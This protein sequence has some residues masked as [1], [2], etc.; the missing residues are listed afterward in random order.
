MI[1]ILICFLAFLMTYS[2][3]RNFRR[4]ILRKKIVDVPNERSSH[5]KPVA[6]GGGLIIVLVCLTFYTIYGLFVSGEFSLSYLIGAGFIA[7]V[8]WIDDLKSIS[9]PARFA[10]HASAAALMIWATGAFSTI[11]LPFL[12]EIQTSYFGVLLTFLWIVWLTNAYNFM[13]GIDGIAALQA[14]IN[15]IGWFYIG[16]LY[17]MEQTSLYG[18]IIAASCFGFLPHNWQPAKIFMGDVGSAFLGFTFA[19]FPLLAVGENSPHT[20]IPDGYLPLIGIVLVWGFL[21]DTVFTLLRRIS[22]FEKIWEAHRQHI[23]QK[24]VIEGLQHSSAAIL[25]GAVAAFTAAV[26]IFCLKFG[27][28]FDGLLAAGLGVSSIGLIFIYLRRKYMV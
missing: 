18:F 16:L 10:V 12:G 14:V 1:K 23:Y 6:R 24:L 28:Y 13:D 20:T 3:V 22:K 21:F 19:V 5:T 7:F 26:L 4:W 15:G 17:G 25:Y 11:Y 2:G 8:S 9:F 27:I